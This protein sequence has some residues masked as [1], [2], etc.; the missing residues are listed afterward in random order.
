M[1][2]NVTEGP[3]DTIFTV[4]SRKTPRSISFADEEDFLFESNDKSSIV[5][6][7][8]KK[9]PLLRKKEKVCLCIFAIT[10]LAALI[11]AEIFMYLF[12]DPEELDENRTN[13]DFSE[14]ADIMRK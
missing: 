3:I 9:V 6:N 11:V 2:E 4:E 10:F 1:I 12:W 13:F 14:Y 5:E 8:N 7:S